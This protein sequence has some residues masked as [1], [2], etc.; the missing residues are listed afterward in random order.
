MV[1]DLVVL[2]ISGDWHCDTA[3][4]V[5]LAGGF[6]VLHWCFL[7]A[8]FCCVVQY[9][10]LGFRGGCLFSGVLGCFSVGFGDCGCRWVV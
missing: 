7:F 2:V 1:V 10:V 6:S 4:W 8:V 5:L 3:G 9:A